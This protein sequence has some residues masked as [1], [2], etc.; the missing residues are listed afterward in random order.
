M[1]RGTSYYIYPVLEWTSCIKNL[2][3]LLTLSCSR[4]GTKVEHTTQRKI[5][6][7]F[8]FAMFV[9]HKGEGCIGQQM[10]PE[11]V[12]NPMTNFSLG[13][14]SDLD[15]WFSTKPKHLVCNAKLYGK[16][17]F[18]KTCL[19]TLSKDKFM[20]HLFRLLS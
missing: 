4:V 12:T 1:N 3:L 16:F 8:M 13:N 18:S 14:G 9:H 19:S 7:N 20:S 11:K 2:L 5:V 15:N 10:N 6:D 17:W